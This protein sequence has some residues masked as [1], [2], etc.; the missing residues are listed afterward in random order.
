[1][2]KSKTIYHNMSNQKH[3]KGDIMPTLFT[4]LLKNGVFTAPSQY[5]TV[6]LSDAHTDANITK[7]LGAYGLSLKAV[8]N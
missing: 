7:A 3:H 8:K 4:N 2:N 5:E 6:F 1:M